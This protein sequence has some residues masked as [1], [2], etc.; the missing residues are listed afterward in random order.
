MGYLFSIFSVLFKERI[1]GFHVAGPNA[2][3]V[4]QGYA[5]AMKLK[6]TKQ[7]FDMTVG[8]HPTIAEVFLSIFFFPHTKYLY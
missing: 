7:D 6:A 1:V 2:G 3:E 4:T 5:V 8:I